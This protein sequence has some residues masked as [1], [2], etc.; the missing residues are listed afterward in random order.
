M[1]VSVCVCHAKIRCEIDDNNRFFLH[2]SISSLFVYV[3]VILCVLIDFS[4]I[5]LTCLLLTK[6]LSF[7]SF[8]F[9]FFPLLIYLNSFFF[10]FFIAK[11]VKCCVRVCVP[12]HTA[13]KIPLP[14]QQ[15]K[16]DF[17]RNLQQIFISIRFFLFILQHNLFVLLSFSNLFIEFLQFFFFIV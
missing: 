10:H 17:L 4:S 8:L 12:T 5:S 2:L 9:R 15:Q 6:I 11:S 14:K 3:S 1:L 7:I 13:S 16:N